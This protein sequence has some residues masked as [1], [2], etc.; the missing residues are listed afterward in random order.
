[1][2]TLGSPFKVFWQSIKDLFDEMFLLLGS[3]ILWVAINLPLCTLVWFMLT[4]GATLLGAV[5]ALL[6]LVP[7]APANAALCYIAQ[8]VAEGRSSKLGHFFE[9]FRQYLTLS[10]RIYLPWGLGLLLIV[11]NLSFYAGMGSNLGS[12]LFV[13][14]LY[15]LLAWFSL[16]IYIGPLMILQQDK[17]IKVIARNAALMVFGRPIFTFFTTLLMGIVVALSFYLLVLPLLLTFS[18]LAIWSMR[19]TRRLIQDAE[20]RRAA[21]EAAQTALQ[22]PPNTDKGRGGQV[23]PRD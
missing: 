5:A 13:L 3:N 21:N 4:G 6:A 14:F 20:A 18:F 2:L 8:R 23:R 19:A 1:M 17:Q 7:M 12:F 15:I 9:G 16:L 11:V 10:W 22:A